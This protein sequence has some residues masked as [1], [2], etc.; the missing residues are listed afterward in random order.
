[1]ESFC[2]VF[3]FNSF[4]YFIRN[5]KKFHSFLLLFYYA[6]F[7][8]ILNLFL[9][10]VYYQSM[11]F[12][13]NVDNT[14]NWKLV[15]WVERINPTNKWDKVSVVVYHQSR[16][17][18]SYFCLKRLAWIWFR[19]E[20]TIFRSKWTTFHIQNEPLLIL[21]PKTKWSTTQFSIKNRQF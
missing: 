3:H 16:I 4:F 12:K 10:H 8:K 20:W 14:F 5:K 11:P 13:G 19:L 2:I 21:H 18:S 17:Q 7:S 9:L 1:M 6:I 15:D